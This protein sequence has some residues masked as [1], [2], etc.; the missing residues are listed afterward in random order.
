MSANEA[1]IVGEACVVAQSALGGAER[2]G[3]PVIAAKDAAGS[4]LYTVA[5]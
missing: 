1:Q 2:Q 5:R 3:L 4:R